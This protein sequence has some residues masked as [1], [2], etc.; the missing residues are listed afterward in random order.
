MR[1]LAAGLLL[2]LAA[3]APAAN[4]E[5]PPVDQF[6]VLYLVRVESRGCST[7]N[8]SFVNETGGTDQQ[9]VNATGYGWWYGINDPRPGQ[10]FGV[11]AYSTCGLDYLG[12]PR[13]SPVTVT[14]YSDG[15]P[16]RRG[17]GQAAYA[18]ASAS[19]ITPLF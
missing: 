5:P 4:Q 8:I 9:Q 1:Q 11:T 12:F 16:V 17:S 3:C 10:V 13:W 19:Y 18:S 15:R 7:A 14:I 6:D 2:V